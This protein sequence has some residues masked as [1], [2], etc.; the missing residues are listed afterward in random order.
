M[1]T[2][3]SLKYQLWNIFYQNMGV[4]AKIGAIFLTEIVSIEKRANKHT[5]VKQ[6]YFSLLT[7]PENV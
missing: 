2:L 4:I 7:E 1:H 3:K 5:I 6:I